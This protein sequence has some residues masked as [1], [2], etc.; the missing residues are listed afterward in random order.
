MGLMFFGF[1][2]FCASIIIFAIHGFAHVSGNAVIAA[3]LA[4][5]VYLFANLYYYK[6]VQ[7]GEVSRVIPLLYLDA[8]ITAVLSGMYLGEIFS[9]LKYLGILLVVLG[10]ILISYQKGLHIKNNKAVWFCLVAALLF[11]VYD[12]L[13]KVSFNNGD[14]WTVFAYIRLA[15]FA[16]LLPMYFLK[17][18]TIVD[19]AVRQTRGFFIVLSSNILG[20]LGVV[21]FGLSVARGYVA[22]AASLAAIQPFTVFLIVLGLSLFYPKVLKEEQGK[23]IFAQKLAAIILM[24]IGVMLIT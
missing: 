6:A 19:L 9:P 2:G 23:M 17:G 13:L 21:F 24:F 18:K 20:I 14:F 12:L 22:L 7:S 16:G 8:L 1:A 15:T 5:F 4:G 11:A 10:A 3:L